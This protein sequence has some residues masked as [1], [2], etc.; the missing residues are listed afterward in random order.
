MIHFFPLMNSNSPLFSFL[1]SVFSFFPMMFGRSILVWVLRIS[2]N[3]WM[4]LLLRLNGLLEFS[5]F[6]GLR[7]GLD[8]SAT[9]F[10]WDGTLSDIF[11]LKDDVDDLDVRRDSLKN[12]NI[13]KSSW[14]TM[15]KRNYNFNTNRLNFHF[16]LPVKRW[17]CFW[18]YGWWQ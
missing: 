1:L 2:G 15:L 8:L 3:D 5:L 14:A 16:W 9:M 18:W 10:D 7:P 6:S 13:Y 11:S 4:L 12:K 17:R